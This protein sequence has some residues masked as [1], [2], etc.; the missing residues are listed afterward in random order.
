MNTDKTIL[1]V[2]D[3]EMV[4]ALISFQLQAAGYQV[5]GA[6]DGKQA[7]QF[8]DGRSIDLVITDLNMPNMNGLEL[9][10]Q[11]RGTEGYQYM[12]VV[13]FVSENAEDKEH[14]KTSGATALLVKDQVNEK[15]NRLVKKMIR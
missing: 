12:P 3:S 4:V 13:L 9:I 11:I 7:T 8:F 14:I 10:S 15:L 6:G 1:L 2:D 5:I